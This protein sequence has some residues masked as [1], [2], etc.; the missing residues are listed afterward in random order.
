METFG[1]LDVN[2]GSGSEEHIAL[3]GP[4]DLDSHSTRESQTWR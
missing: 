4:G 2:S 3:W 1:Q